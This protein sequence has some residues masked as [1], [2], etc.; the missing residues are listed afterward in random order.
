MK[1]RYYHNCTKYFYSKKRFRNDIGIIT[2]DYKD[3]TYKLK[4]IANNHRKIGPARIFE[5]KFSGTKEWWN[6]GFVHRDNGPS[7]IYYFNKACDPKII[8]WFKGI[9]LSSNEECYW[10][11]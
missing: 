3:I 9:N 4:T 11:K 1:F 10:N 8:W 7:E 5:T 6:N 2:N